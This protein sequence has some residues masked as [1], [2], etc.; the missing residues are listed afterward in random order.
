M[1]AKQLRERCQ[2]N[3]FTVTDMEPAVVKKIVR[4]ILSA[5]E[6]AER[7]FIAAESQ[8]AL[9]D[10]LAAS[11][12]SSTVP[13]CPH[14]QLPPVLP[15]V[16]TPEIHA[17]IEQN[18]ARDWAL[19]DAGMQHEATTGLRSS[20]VRP[21]QEEQD[22]SALQIALQHAKD[23][24]AAARRTISGEDHPVNMHIDGALKEIAYLEGLRAEAA[25]ASPQEGVE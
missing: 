24:L 17:A 13:T 11:A 3:V 6:E 22:V 12:S 5:L 2:M 8:L 25:A 19:F 14:C 23:A 7:R 10:S 20:T 1:T 4:Q 16:C 15:E 21:P 9:I 18:I